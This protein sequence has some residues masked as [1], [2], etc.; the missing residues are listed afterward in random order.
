MTLTFKDADE[1][2][3]W[4]R[5]VAGFALANNPYLYADQALLERRKRM[6]KQSVELSATQKGLGT[7]LYAEM[8]SELNEIQPTPEADA[9]GW[10]PHKPGDPMP[11]DGALL[12]LAKGP[13]TISQA[14]ARFIDWKTVLAWR[15]AQ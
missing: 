15:P 14:H 9:D 4:D 7:D 12:V 1:A 13:Q 6:P 2:Q 8:I 11:C 3:A 5:Y 10:I